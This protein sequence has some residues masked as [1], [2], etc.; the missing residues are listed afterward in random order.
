[1]PTDRWGSPLR[2]AQLWASGNLFGG[3][4]G[5]LFSWNHGLIL[6]SPAVLVALPGWR[7]LFKT[8]RRS[9]W[10]CATTIVPYFLLMSL[11]STWWGGHCYGPRLILPIIPLLFLGIVETFASLA[12]RSARFQQAALVTC[13]L[14]LLISATGALVHLAF[15]SQHPLITPL[16]LLARHI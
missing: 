13:T 14:S 6:F 4:L 7:T 1:M 15:W 9:A 11:W 16:L 12:E 3:I 8:Q 5:L 10:I 2:T